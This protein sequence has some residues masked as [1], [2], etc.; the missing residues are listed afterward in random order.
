MARTTS[1]E[2]LNDGAPSV[3]AL[4]ASILDGSASR[5]LIG[6][7]L[8]FYDGPA[9]EGLPFGQFGEHGVVSRTESLVLT[10]RDP[11]RS[12]QERRHGA[13]AAGVAAVPC[14]GWRS[15]MDDGVS[16]KNFVIACRRWPD[17][18]SNPAAPGRR[19]PR[20]TLSP[21]NGGTTTARARPTGRAGGCS[22]PR[23]IR[24]EARPP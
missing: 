4:H 8:N 9:F 5:R 21:P 13:D 1:Y 24:W 16:R 14:A 11:A 20:V 10:E 18:S 17:T 15:G 23:A 7:T 2:I 22:S 3:F 19:M 12:L 6:Q